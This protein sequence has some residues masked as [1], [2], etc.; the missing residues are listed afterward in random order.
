M[1]NLQI[2]QIREAGRI[3]LV[4]AFAAGFVDAVGY[5]VL[6]QI[7]TAH[8]SGNTVAMC[9]QFSQHNWV[10]LLRR[11]FPIPMFLLGTALGTFLNLVLPRF[12]LQWTFSLIF[13]LEVLLLL[14]FI[15]LGQ[16]AYIAGHEH[17]EFNVRYYVLLTLLPIAMGLQNSTIRHIGGSTVHTT[18]VSGLLTSLTIEIVGYFFRNSGRARGQLA[19]SSTDETS[20][21]RIALMSGVYAAYLTGAVLGGFAE[22][23]WAL[24]SLLMPVCC[25]CVVIFFDLSHPHLETTV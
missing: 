7:F 11:G 18:Y 19:S 21:N 12:G 8:M 9:V 1:P 10:E 22:T 17:F 3:V 6:F 20:L 25:L 4:L 5:I 23:L 13:T 2:Q 24:V 16:S 15:L 14:S